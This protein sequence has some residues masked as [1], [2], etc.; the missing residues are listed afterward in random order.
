M[1]AVKP[2]VADSISRMAVTSVKL[3]WKREP[4]S[5]ETQNKIHPG[6]SAC[7]AIPLLPFVGLNI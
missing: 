3:E 5:I 4:L 1:L 6:N 7:D 2:M